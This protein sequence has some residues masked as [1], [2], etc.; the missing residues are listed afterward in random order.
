MCA[1]IDISMMNSEE[2]KVSCE[3]GTVRYAFKQVQFELYFLPLKSKTKYLVEIVYHRKVKHFAHISA[4]DPK[5]ST[6]C[7]LAPHT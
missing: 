4:E 2:H 7:L 5:S 3:H 1:H 6:L